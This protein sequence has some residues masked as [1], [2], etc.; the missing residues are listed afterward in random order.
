MAE[1]YNSFE[2]GKLEFN[3]IIPE[4]WNTYITAFIFRAL[5]ANEYI[6][7]NMLYQR[8]WNMMKDRYKTEITVV[9]FKPIVEILIKLGAISRI[10]GGRL[11]I[12]W[13]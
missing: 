4:H 12:Q 13:R 8:V 3:G 11:I 7:E 1:K 2:P 10:S 5:R 9:V 6:E